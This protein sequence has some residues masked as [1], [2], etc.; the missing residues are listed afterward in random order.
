MNA[1]GMVS[2]VYVVEQWLGR[3][4][5]VTSEATVLGVLFAIFLLIEPAILLGLAAWTSRAWTGV[6]MGL[7]PLAVRYTY[8]LAPLGFGMWLA[9]YGYHFLTGLYTIVPVTQN[10]FVDVGWPIFGAPQWTL[11]GL[12]LYMVEPIE[13]GFLL[14]GMAGSLLVLWRFAEED[15]AE[16]PVRL[17]VPWAVVCMLLLLAAVWLITQPMDMRATMMAG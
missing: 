8:C 10:A 15:S 7:L 17:F 3:L 13:F 12:P 5:H 6:K 1:F 16:H 4:L 2:P 14:L 9:H 11:V